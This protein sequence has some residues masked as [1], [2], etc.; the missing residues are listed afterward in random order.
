CQDC[1]ARRKRPGRPSW[2]HQPAAK[3]SRRAY[4]SSPRGRAMYRVADA[5]RRERHAEKRRAQE[6][7]RRALI[8]GDIE[9]VA[10]CE[11]DCGRPALEMHHAEYAAPL[12]VQWVCRA[13]HTRL[14]H[15]N[16]GRA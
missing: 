16:A 14:H 10:A 1:C 7:A 11:L 3:A 4:R 13:C 12:D 8:R 15:P 5:R 2:E 6:T 9:R